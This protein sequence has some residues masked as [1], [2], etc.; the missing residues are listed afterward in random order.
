MR[1]LYV[2]A[3]CDLR[4]TSTDFRTKQDETSASSGARILKLLNEGDR[5][6]MLC[7][8]PPKATTQHHA[9]SNL[10][11]GVRRRTDN[12][13]PQDQIWVNGSLTYNDCCVLASVDRRQR[14]SKQQQ[15]GVGVVSQ[16]HRLSNFSQADHDSLKCRSRYTYATTQTVSRPMLH[17]QP[18]VSNTVRAWAATAAMQHRASEWLL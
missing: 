8:R 12:D 15:Q 4:V 13:Y 17:G 3:Q 2:H 6:C 14:K 7:A 5:N 9:D 16:R 11:T 18:W 10:V 1:K